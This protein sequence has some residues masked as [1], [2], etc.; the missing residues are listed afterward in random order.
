MNRFQPTKKR[1]YKHQLKKHIYCKSPQLQL[2]AVAGNNSRLR[3]R[4]LRLN[5]VHLR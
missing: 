1:R 5:V 3:D 4:T 2:N